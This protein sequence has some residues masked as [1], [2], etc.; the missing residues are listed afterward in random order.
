MTFDINA[1]RLDW[2]F[3]LE[4]VGAL[5]GCLHVSVTTRRLSAFKNGIVLPAFKLLNHDAV[6]AGGARLLR[7]VTCVYSH[8]DIFL[9]SGCY[10]LSEE[11]GLRQ[12][13]PGPEAVAGGRE[14]RW[15]SHPLCAAEEVRAGIGRHCH[16]RRVCVNGAS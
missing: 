11:T 8:V 13:S 2:T 9:H 10:F 1:G 6:M 12:Y 5:T 4:P 14:L 3:K 15:L 7:N 16:K